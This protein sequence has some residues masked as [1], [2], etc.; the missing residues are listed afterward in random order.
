MININTN[1]PAL[2]GTSS[3]ELEV[4]LVQS[5]TACMP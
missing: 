1:Q 3:V 4:L 5:F 2:A